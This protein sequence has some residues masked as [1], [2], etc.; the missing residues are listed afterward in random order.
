MVAPGTTII[1]RAK[2][3]KNHA[4]SAGQLRT[5]KRAKEIFI[6]RNSAVVELFTLKR[7]VFLQS[8]KPEVKQV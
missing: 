8:V 7:A 3:A 4:L 6:K 5:Q 2:I 1:R